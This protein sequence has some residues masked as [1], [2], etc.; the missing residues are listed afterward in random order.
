[1]RVLFDQ[2]TP[3]SLRHHLWGQQ[4]ATANERG[5]AKLKNGQ[6]LHAAETS[7]FVVLVTTDRNLKYQQNLKSRRI[8]IVVLSTP[9]WSRIQ[10]AVADVVRAVD[11]ATE[12]G[13]IELRIP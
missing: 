13:Y 7:G 5:W 6:L 9:L 4:V 8:A 1:M 3:A 2:G 10:N 11:A 12:G